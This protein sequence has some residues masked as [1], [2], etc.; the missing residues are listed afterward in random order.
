MHLRRLNAPAVVASFLLAA[1]IWNPD[2]A[3]AAPILRDPGKDVGAPAD[4]P[5]AAAFRRGVQALLRNDLATAQREFAGA[6][7]LDSRVAEPLLGLA[8]VASRQGRTKEAEAYLKRAQA[9]APSNPAVYLGLGRF[10]RGQRDPVRAE[11]A[12]KRAVQ[13]GTAVAPA[14]IELGDLYLEQRRSS[15]SVQQFQRAVQIRPDSAFAHYGLGVALSLGGK[16]QEAA[17]ALEKAAALAPKDIAPLQALA[18]LH[19]EQRSFDKALATIDAAIKLA[20]KLPQLQL[21]RADILAA[22]GDTN[23]ALEQGRRVAREFPDVA[24]VHFRLANL[25]VQSGDTAAAEAAYRETVKRDQGNAMALNNLAWLLAERKAN[26]DE[27]LSF[28]KQALS[29]QPRNAVFLDTLGW[30]HRARGEAGDA[31][32]AFEQASDADPRFADSPFHL[33]LVQMESGRN[34][35]AAAALERALKLGLTEPR[36]ADARKRLASLRSAN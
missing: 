7:R 4:S 18:R 15:E 35:E 14:H 32:R 34:Q 6:E 24:E 30:V 17:A 31:I 26:L 10:Y 11:A 8:D 9:L 13:I 22:R 27:A 16:P 33:G 1:S 12:L 21:D 5:A 20:P 3:S 2:I 36:A 28:A 23:A 19:T 25:L 29:L